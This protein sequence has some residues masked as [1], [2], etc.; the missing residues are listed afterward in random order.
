MTA[1]VGPLHYV[2]GSHAWQQPTGHEKGTRHFFANQKDHNGWALVQAAHDQHVQ[3]QHEQEQQE[4]Q[5]ETDAS[6]KETAQPATTTPTILD[7]PVVSLTNLPA[8]SIAI[9][10]GHTWHGSTANGSTSQ[11]RHGW[12]LHMIPLHRVCGFHATAQYS[13]LWKPYYQRQE[14][15]QERQQERQERQQEHERP[16]PFTDSSNQSSSPT[17]TTMVN[18]L[19][20]EDFP[21]VWQSTTTTTR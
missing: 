9:H 21:I 8:G 13:R 5:Q 16:D 2:A 6:T 17:T 12:G 20:L 7:V 11:W 3:W 14:Q 4:Q 15:E 10:D 18:G 1:E 19:D